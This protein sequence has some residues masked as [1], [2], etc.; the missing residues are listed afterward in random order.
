MG[1]KQGKLVEIGGNGSHVKIQ[2]RRFWADDSAQ[3]EQ[4]VQMI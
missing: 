3:Q 2:D 1:S 4:L